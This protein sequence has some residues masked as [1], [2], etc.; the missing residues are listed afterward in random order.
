MFAV[1][2]WIAVCIFLFGVGSAGAEDL[3]GVPIVAGTSYTLHSKILGDDREVNVWLPAGYGK[4]NT[5]YSVLYVLDGARDQDFGHIVGLG[6]LGELSA[7]YE[8]LIVVGV[9]TRKRIWELTP[10]AHDPRYIKAFPEN[11]GAPVFRRF[12]NDEVVP[13]VENH[14]RTGARRAIMGESLAGLFVADTFL[15]SP[16]AFDDYISVSPSLWWDDRALTRPTPALPAAKDLTGRRLYLTMGDEGGTS[17]KGMDEL[18]AALRAHPQPGLTW[19]F[20]DRSASESHA[21]IY[22]VSALDALRTFYKLPPYDTGPT[23][24]WNV[25]GGSPP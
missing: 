16:R 15:E 6:Q 5:R 22:H 21:T 9:Q 12:L 14:F 3:T 20:V 8:T 1:R 11:G 4:G 17:R 7:T 24:W 19:T 10:K 25:E 13:F 2:L 18:V 23:P